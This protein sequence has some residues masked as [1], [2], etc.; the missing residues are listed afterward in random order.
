[1]SRLKSQAGEEGM[2]D[3]WVRNFDPKSQWFN[4]PN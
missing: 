3:V 2:G 4:T 1:M